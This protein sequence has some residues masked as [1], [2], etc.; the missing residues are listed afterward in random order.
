M[1]FNNKIFAINPDGTDVP[2]YPLEID[3][4]TKAGIALADFNNNGKV[5]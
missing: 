4:K 3:E 5:L 1:R 2:G